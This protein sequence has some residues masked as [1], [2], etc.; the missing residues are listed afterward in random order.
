MVDYIVVGAGSAG[1]VI[2]NRLSAAASNQV[3]VLEAGPEDKDRF[4]HIPA[5]FAQLFRTERDWDYSTTPQTQYRRSTR[6][7]GA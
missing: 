1:S 4:V 7:H 6:H 2:A 3:M 5:G